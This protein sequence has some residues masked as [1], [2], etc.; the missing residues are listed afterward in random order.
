MRNPHLGK[1]P[2]PQYSLGVEALS[3]WPLKRSVFRDGQQSPDRQGAL[4]DLLQAI[5][6][7]LFGDDDVVDVA[8]PESSGGEAAEAR[9]FL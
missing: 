3:E 4:R 5:V 7:R 6:R 2:T 1:L 8:F 9:I